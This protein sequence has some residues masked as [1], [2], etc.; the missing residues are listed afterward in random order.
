MALYPEAFLF[1]IFFVAA[2]IAQ[3]GLN[4]YNLLFHLKIKT[5]PK[6]LGGF[7][8]KSQLSKNVNQISISTC[9]AVD[10]FF[11]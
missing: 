4:V 2:H 1:L 11:V 6:V 9:N 7:S 10:F 5:R 8:V 3:Y